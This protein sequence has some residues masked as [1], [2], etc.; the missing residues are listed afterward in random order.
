MIMKISTSQM[1]YTGTTN[2]LNNQSSV[3]RTQNQLSTG[4]KI[5]SPRDNPV[6]SAMALMTTQSKEVNATFLKNQ[7]M[8][9]DRLAF[10]DTQLGAA[11]EQLSEAI[12]RS[13]QGGN[14]TYGPTDKQAIADDL[15][16]RFESLMNIANSKDGT[17]EYI[18]AGNR[19]NVQ[20]F[21]VT[22]SAGNYSLA[23]TPVVSYSGDDSL[24]MLQ[25]E[26]TQTIA[27]NESGQAVFMRVMDANGNLNGRSVFDALQNMID[28]L[29]SS[30]GVTPKPSYD[31]ALGDL[32]SALDH[33][34]RMRASV[35]A[36][37]NQLDS[38]TSA[39]SDVSVQYET[40]LAKL[41]GLDYAE[42][43]SQL[44]QQQMQL[45]ASQLSFKKASELSLFSIL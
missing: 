26:S 9:S 34:S 17:G 18:F 27:T 43:I 42:A 30:S 45:Q 29:D 35:G 19:S 6:D 21:S 11:S 41:E 8:A 38:L 31:Q 24:R 5:M 40:Q 13:I 16:R 10:L 25:V 22:G 3:Y 14:S 37:M 1:F 7:G 33:I 36:S 2:I 15:K 39:G 4:R 32:Q 28:N 44:S 23:G 20:P 12:S